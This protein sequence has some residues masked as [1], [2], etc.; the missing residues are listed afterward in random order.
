MQSY[1]VKIHAK[2]VMLSTF[3]NAQLFDF[4][5]RIC[6]VCLACNATH[7]SSVDD[8]D[9]DDDDCLED[10]FVHVNI[11]EEII[12]SWLVK[13]QLHCYQCN[14]SLVEIQ[15]PD[16]C[17]ACSQ[18]EDCN[19]DDDDDNNNNN[20]NNDG[21]NQ[22]TDAADDDVTVLEPS[23]I[24]MDDYDMV[25]ETMR[26]LSQEEDYFLTELQPTPP[27]PPPPSPADVLNLMCLEEIT[28]L[29]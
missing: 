9:D 11:P 19:D 3:F 26:A 14:K 12:Y 25:M 6:F 27:P 16:K 28:E 4:E 15:T 22:H 18:P 29:L 5:E 8:D 2:I 21:E 17:W 23:E 7:I 24:K 13:H 10:H 1:C 20:N